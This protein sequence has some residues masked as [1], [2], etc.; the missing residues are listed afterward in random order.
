[1]YK[2]WTYYFGSPNNVGQDPPLDTTIKRYNTNIQWP[3]SLCIHVLH[4][5]VAPLFKYDFKWFRDT[6]YKP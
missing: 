3:K 1:M 2:F 6:N 4:S 5:G